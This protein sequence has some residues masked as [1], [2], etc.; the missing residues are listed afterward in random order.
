[1][2]CTE[3]KESPISESSIFEYLGTFGHVKGVIHQHIAVSTSSCSRYWIVEFSDVGGLEKCLAKLEHVL[4]NGIFFWNFVKKFLRKNP[5]RK[6]C[7]VTVTPDTKILIFC[8]KNFLLDNRLKNYYFSSAVHSESTL[9]T[10]RPPNETSKRQNE[11]SWG[12]KT[13]KCR[14]PSS[15][16]RENTPPTLNDFQISRKHSGECKRYKNDKKIRC[17]FLVLEYVAAPILSGYGYTAKRS[18]MDWHSKADNRL[19]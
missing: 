19:F 16:G 14:N 17:K 11:G 18:R 8:V 2:C 1:M 12:G 9:E 3:P 13:E 7:L 4:N 6:S 10:R 15:K 5:D